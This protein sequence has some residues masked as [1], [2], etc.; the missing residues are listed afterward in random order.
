MENIDIFTSIQKNYLSWILIFVSI[1]I[2]SYP[3]I[4]AGF[5]TFFILLFLAYFLHRFSHNYKNVLTILHHYHHENNNFFS[6]FS[7][8][9]LE[10]SFIMLVIPFYNSFG[11]GNAFIDIWTA[12][13]FILFYST[14]HNYN[15]GQLRVNEV[16]Y[17]HHTNIYTNIGPDICDVAFGTKHPDNKEVEN[18]NHYIPNLIIITICLA[19]IKYYLFSLDELKTSITS[20]FTKLLNLSVLFIVFSSICLYCTYIPASYTN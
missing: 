19:F 18:T 16:H 11:N 9:L 13:L 20:I 3:V 7:Q 14:V 12:I 5:I 2:V 10:L 8:I 6:H 17:Q 4:S 1:I 15:Y